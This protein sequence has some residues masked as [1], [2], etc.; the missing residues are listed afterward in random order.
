MSAAIQTSTLGVIV[1]KEFEIQYRVARPLSLVHQILS[2]IQKF[3]SYHPLLERVDKVSETDFILHE[4]S[5]LPLGLKL[6][7]HYR[8]RVSFGSKPEFVRYEA[9]PMG[10]GLSITFH[11]ETDSLSKVTVVRE[12]I[13]IIGWAIFLGPLEKALRASH[14]AVFKNIEE[15]A[16]T[17][18]SMKS[19]SL[20]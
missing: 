20:P 3:G 5:P 10:V 2:D 8:A 15:K 14:Q 4:F 18:V 11:L 17:P 13:T 9:K 12:E 19:R 7:F 1:I 16:D 6:R